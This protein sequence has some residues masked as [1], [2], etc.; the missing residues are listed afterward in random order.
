MRHIPMKK[1]NSRSGRMTEARL[2]KNEAAVVIEVA[3]HAMPASFHMYLMRP[4][5]SVRSRPLRSGF[6]KATKTNM[7]STPKPAMRNN[8]KKHAAVTRVVPP[9]TADVTNAAGMDKAVRK[10]TLTLRKKLRVC[11]VK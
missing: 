4:G 5:T 8:D 6:Q 3:K 1:P 7:L 9:T 10:R 2:A 11:K